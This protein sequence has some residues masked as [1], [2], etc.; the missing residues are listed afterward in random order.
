MRSQ[1]ETGGTEKGVK[2]TEEQERQRS[3]IDREAK[4][5]EE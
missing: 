2:E 3:E 4:E 1:R 5:R